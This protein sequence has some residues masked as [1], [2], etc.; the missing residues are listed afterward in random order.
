MASSNNNSVTSLSAELYSQ[1][2]RKFFP[3]P[4]TMP[5]GG[6]QRSDTLSG[7][8]VVDHLH[9]VMRSTFPCLS[10]RSIGMNGS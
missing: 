8:R 10:G 9:R 1:L 6:D 3:V 4:E 7:R 5:E 2:F